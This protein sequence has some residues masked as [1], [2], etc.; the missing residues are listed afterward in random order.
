MIKKS[1]IGGSIIYGVVLLGFYLFQ[2]KVVFRSKKL[3][4]D[5]K[6][7]FVKPF[8]EITFAS[9][10]N[11]RIHALHF[12]VDKPKGILLYFHGNKGNLARWGEIVSPYTAY[13]YDVFVMDYRGY[14]KSNG[15]RSERAMYA[16]ALKAYEQVK[17]LG[18]AEHE[19]VVYGRSLGCTFATYVASMNQPK[20]VILEAPFN[21]LREIVR[22][23]FPLLPYKFLLK[24]PFNTNQF[25]ANV[26]SPTVIFHG[27]QDALI[28]I[29]SG[30]QLYDS[31]N[32]ANTAFI[33]IQ[34]G[35]H[36]NITT[37]DAYTEKLKTLLD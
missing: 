14:G 5:F 10:D 26:T 15:K 17:A 25:I 28:P 7:S 11:G 4:Q 37:F 33:P 29:A 6:F 32:K 20:Q 31:A 24:Y 34:M 8:N 23:K 36:H 12:T 13:N 9:N 30:R 16:D 35:T 27:D 18:Y 2:E 21:S 22:R 3:A 1:I 19:I